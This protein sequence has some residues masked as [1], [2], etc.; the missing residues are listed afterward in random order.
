MDDQYPGFIEFPNETNVADKWSTAVNNYAS[1]VVPAS[2]TAAQAKT[3]M[4]AALTGMSAPGAALV[5][6]PTSFTVYAT[7]LAVGMA[8]TYVGTPPPAPIILT[9]AFT[10]GSAG[11]SAADV[12]QQ[13]VLIID[14]WFR[15]GTA[16]PSAGG[17]PIPWS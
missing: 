15:T 16:T 4:Q 10:I 7:T 14:L 11:G 1:A 12:I 17:A 3:A 5:Q 13:L 8:P 6:L 2:T 9:P